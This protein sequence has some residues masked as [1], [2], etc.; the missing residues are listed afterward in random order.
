MFFMILGLLNPA[1]LSG[2]AEMIRAVK[3]FKELRWLQADL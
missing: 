3:G 2:L 1:E